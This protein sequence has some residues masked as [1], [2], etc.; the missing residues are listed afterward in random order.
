MAEQAA[1]SKGFWERLSGRERVL[2]TV[3]GMALLSALIYQ[4]PYSMRER[5][6]ASLRA[7]ASA[8]DLEIQELAARHTELRVRSAEI[9]AGGAG[10][11][12]AR[13]LVDQQGVITVLDDV[14]GEARRLGVNLVS[15]HPSREVD[16]ENYKEV[17]MNL[18]LK[19]RYRDLGEYFRRLEALARVVNIRK[20]RMEA[21]PDASS[22]CAVQVEA[23]AYVAK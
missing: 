6:V 18:D 15:I 13:A 4:Y 23:V 14:S 1:A 19:A 3:T 17:A 12:Q 7:A 5:A 20:L 8:T 22:V 9:K 16:K 2:L 11:L 21:C 10:A